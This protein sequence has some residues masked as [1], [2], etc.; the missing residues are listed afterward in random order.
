MGKVP[1]APLETVA[2]DG[3]ALA[4]CVCYQ[5]WSLSGHRT[6]LQQEHRSIGGKGGLSRLDM[7]EGLH[8]NKEA[9]VEQGGFLRKDRM[10]PFFP[11]GCVFVLK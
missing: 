10:C 4:G 1:Q 5:G 8:G 7:V 2:A 3:W 9:I 11:Q 6:G